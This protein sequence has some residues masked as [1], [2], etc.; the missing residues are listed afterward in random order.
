MEIIHSKRNDFVII[1]PGEAL[2][3]YD[4]RHKNRPVNMSKVKQY[5][6]AMQA[7]EWK[8]CTTLQFLDGRL[9]DGQHRMLACI[10]SGVPFQGYVNYHSDTEQF[11]VYDTGKNRTNSDVLAIAGVKHYK[12]ASSACAIL[13]QVYSKNGLSRSTS[14][15][16]HIPTYEIEKVFMKYPD[17]E[18]S[19]SLYAS[20]KKFF[21][22]PSASAVPLHYI[23][24]KAEI[25]T[26]D[27]EGLESFMAD[28]FFLD[29]LMKGFGLYEH[30]PVA[31]FR[32]YIQKC[33]AQEV[34]GTDRITHH[35]MICGGI[36]VWNRL[37]RGQSMSRFV[38]PKSTHLPRIIL[39]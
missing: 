15:T 17:L 30:H 32:N 33:Y 27:T 6:K 1:N 36:S 2:S 35:A 12:M 14:G 5:T 11:S 10:N 20:G 8:P 29:H 7:G 4:Q 21:K 37:V 22:I 16:S 18:Y 13:E 24:R 34:K 31:T 23:L 3:I 39:P 9:E 28:K 19:C 25:G 38:V 26:P